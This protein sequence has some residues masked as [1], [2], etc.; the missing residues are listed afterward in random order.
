MA[1]IAMAAIPSTIPATIGTRACIVTSFF[2]WLNALLRAPLSRELA[3]VFAASPARSSFLVLPSPNLSSV[4]VLQGGTGG[5]ERGGRGEGGATVTS[6]TVAAVGMF[7]TIPATLIGISGAV[8]VISAVTPIIAINGDVSISGAGVVGK[9]APFGSPADQRDTCG[10][11]LASLLSRVAVASTRRLL[12][13]I[14][15][16]M[17]ITTGNGERGE[18][19]AERR[20][21][22]SRERM[23]GAF[24]SP[25]YVHFVMPPFDAVFAVAVAV[26]GMVFVSILHGG[27][28]AAASRRGLRG[29]LDTAASH[30]IRA[31][32]QEDAIAGRTG[33]SGGAD[34]S[35]LAAGVKKR[36][37]AAAAVDTGITT[38]L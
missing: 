3:L 6:A 36:A 15:A 35:H 10:L 19:G 13:A 21:R 9:S 29:R 32:G 34:M 23:L 20:V 25:A 31:R 1:A 16:T 33:T 30:R 7:M 2:D 18:E 38:G 27:D 12:G 22:V 28:L 14:S 11:F 4:L 5:W 37:A 24:G 26:V 8:T 17:S